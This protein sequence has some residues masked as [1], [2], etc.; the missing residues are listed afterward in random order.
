M[1]ERMPEIIKECAPDTEEESNEEDDDVVPMETAL[2]ND[3]DI[4]DEEEQQVIAETVS[5]KEP[6]VVPNVRN[7][8][9]LWWTVFYLVVV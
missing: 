8:L 4:A 7:K 2:S 1:N 6:S 9:W 3:K 5:S